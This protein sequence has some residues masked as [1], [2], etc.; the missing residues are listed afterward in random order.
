MP[1]TTSGFASVVM[2]PGL[3]KLEMP[4]MTRRMILPERV[5]GMSATIHTF[6]GLAI[7]PIRCSIAPETLSSICLLGLRP[8][9]SATYISTARPRSSST[10]GTAAASAISSTVNAA[11]SSSFVPRRSGDVDDVVDAA[12]NPE[13][14]VLGEQGAVTGEVR[15]VVEVLALGVLVVLLEVGADE[16]VRVAPDGLEDPGPRVLDAD[17]ARLAAS[18]WNLVAVL[19]EDHR[20]DT[21]HAGSGAAGLHLVERRQR[22][23][24][25]SSVL[26]LPP[27]VDD[28]GLV[29]AH[30]VV[31]PA[32]HFGLDR[33]ADRGH[34]LEVVVVLAR[35]VRA[36]LAQHADGR[37][38]RVEDVHAQTL[39]DPPRPARVGIRGYALVH[40]AG[41]PQGE[42]PIDDV[43][44]TGDPAD[45]GEAPVGVFGMDVLVVLR[46]A[47]DVSQVAPCAVLAALRSGG[48]AAGV[49]EEQRRLGRHRHRIYALALVVGQQVV[50]DEVT[51]VDQGRLG[52]VLA[53]VALPDQDL[54]DL[55]PLLLGHGDRLVG[56]HLVVEQLTVAVVGVH[57]DQH[58]AL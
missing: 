42:R 15:P 20:E 41:R 22:R 4:A 52:R 2:S 39:G 48:G 27:R 50:D 21:Q 53:G 23:A 3:V 31:V 44:V 6:F 12:E 58:V 49:H 24:E 47:G 7:L 45:V 43:R 35:L 40:H 36:E 8:G 37:R 57:G 32:P 55:V 13:V 1:S 19:V 26:G 18:L 14:A 10:T 25:K 16:L 5:F 17:V 34:V 51:A 33:L 9:L 46:G 28:H 38:G 11:D 30:R 29:L 56:L 54:F